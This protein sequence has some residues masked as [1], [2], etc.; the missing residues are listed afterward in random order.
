MQCIQIKDTY[1]DT[2]RYVFNIL[3]YNTLYSR[4]TLHTVFKVWIPLL[5]EMS[6]LL[7]NGEHCFSLLMYG[8]CSNRVLYS[9]IHS[10]TMLIGQAAAPR[11]VLQIRVCR[12]FP[13]GIESLIFSNFLAWSF[14][15]KTFFAPNTD[16]IGEKW[17][18]N[19]YM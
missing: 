13:L 14:F 8:F 9:A 2:E 10:F 18:K 15:R 7:N 3:K 11:Q 19:K 1:L 12:S 4:P 17:A 5:I 6:Y 16:K